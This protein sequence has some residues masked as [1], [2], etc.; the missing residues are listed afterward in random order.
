MSNNVLRRACI[1]HVGAM[2]LPSSLFWI[3]NFIFLVTRRHIWPPVIGFNI[4]VIF[5][6]S[7]ILYHSLLRLS[8]W[9]WTLMLMIYNLIYYI[10]K[11]LPRKEKWDTIFQFGCSNIFF[12]K[13]LWFLIFIGM[14]RGDNSYWWVV[15][16]LCQTLGILQHSSI[17]TQ[18]KKYKL[19]YY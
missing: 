5:I 14:G 18:R 11:N 6:C 4:F 8:T 13:F 17:Q 9:W 1:M 15:F 3:L 16:I 10:I 19:K 12:S 7:L 2:A